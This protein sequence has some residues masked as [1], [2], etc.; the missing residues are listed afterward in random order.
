ME[1]YRPLI[2]AR[3]AVIY[4]LRQLIK[5]TSINFLFIYNPWRPTR[6][7]GIFISLCMSFKYFMR[8]K[9][10]LTPWYF[11]ATLV[12]LELVINSR[13]K[14]LSVLIYSRNQ[15]VLLFEKTTIPRSIDV[16]SAI[17]LP[18]MC[19]PANFGMVTV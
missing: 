16:R 19:S 5:G 3:K 14:N 17:K 11:R 18:Y 9:V 13:F 6:T 10:L 8:F 15:H 4:F 1:K 12:Y 7:L 2:T